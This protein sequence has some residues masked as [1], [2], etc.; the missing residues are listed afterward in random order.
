MSVKRSKKRTFDGW[1]P[2]DP[3]LFRSDRR[4]WI[5]EDEHREGVTRDI[6][7]WVARQKRLAARKGVA[8]WQA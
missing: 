3:T 1:P 6:A 5:S 4:T 2:L 7:A 8:P